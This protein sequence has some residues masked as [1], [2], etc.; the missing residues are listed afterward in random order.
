MNDDYFYD[1]KYKIIQYSSLPGALLKKRNQLSHCWAARRGTG[2]PGA[3]ARGRRAAAHPTTVPT[4]HR[5][6]APRAAR[7]SSCRGTTIVI[8]PPTTVFPTTARARPSTAAQPLGRALH[9][10]ERVHTTTT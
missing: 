1:C 7:V 4:V 9:T 10:E 6:S 5:S 8:V 2:L 3:R